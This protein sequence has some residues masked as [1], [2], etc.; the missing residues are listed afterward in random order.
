MRLL[1]QSS[2]L[3][4]FHVTIFLV[5]AVIQPLRSS[6]ATQYL[7]CAPAQ[8]S[9]GNVVVGKTAV[10]PVEL[11]NTGQTS[12]TIS[13]ISVVG[14]EFKASG[15]SLPAALAAGQSIRLNVT[16]APTKN[17]WAGATI[18]FTDTS[19]TPHLS[20]SA[21]GTGSTVQPVTA[22]PA[23]V[24]FGNVE[25]GTR[26]RLTFQ[27][28]NTVANKITLTNVLVSGSAFLV[29]GLTLPAVLAPHQSVKVSITFAPQ[30]AGPTSGSIF[31][32]GANGPGLNIPVTGTGAMGQLTVSPTALNFGN[33]DVDTT[34]TKTVTV[35]A[36]DASVTISSAA[37]SNSEFKISGT[38]FP[39]TVG[40][41]QNAK[42]NI[43]FSPTKS[44]TASAKL[45]FTSNASDN[46]AVDSLSGVG[47]LPKYSVALSWN[48]STSSVAGYN[49]YR[50]T[51][52]GSYSRIN[53]TLDPSTSYTD[54]TVA[55][56]VTYYYAATAVNSK[57]EESGYSKPLQ[58]VVP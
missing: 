23:L 32:Y 40:A 27:L 8:I 50:G 6:A 44:G 7:S 28:A 15:I 33:V 45:T 38:S 26:D 39:L 2:V 35:S 20:L 30:K 14:S 42:L 16:F 19:T 18:T 21:E 29:S 51:T 37:S 17:V 52:V 1:P 13:S 55:S 11:T 53:A 4:V 34:T 54:E 25:V 9:F 31:L 10:Q 46:P 5:F 58:V 3:R 41:G 24:A 47:V 49:V 57:G 48:P 36:S 12:M 43:E 56:G 22:V